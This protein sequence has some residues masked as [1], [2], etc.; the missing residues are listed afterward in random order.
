MILVNID[1]IT[2]K[3]LETIGLVNGWEI[4]MFRINLEKAA[5]AANEVIIKNAREMNADAI[6]NV[7]Y[8]FSG[9]GKCVLATDTA[10]KFVS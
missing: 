4:G 7:R 1:Y 2:G 10:V 3:N 5:N 6:V 9:D 8:S